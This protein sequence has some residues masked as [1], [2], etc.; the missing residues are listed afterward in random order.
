MFV[1]KHYHWHNNK[2]W[3][4]AYLGYTLRMKM[5]FRGWPVMAH[6]MHMRRR[7]LTGCRGNK[8]STRYCEKVVCYLTV[9]FSQYLA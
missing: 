1:Y 4:A 5:L 7:P 9:D 3:M 2:N 6:A 8:V